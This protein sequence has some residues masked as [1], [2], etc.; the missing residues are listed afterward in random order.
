MVYGQNGKVS[1]YVHPLVDGWT[2]YQLP[3]GS[4]P[5]SHHTVVS[6]LIDPAAGPYAHHGPWRLLKD[7]RLITEI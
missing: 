4:I 7:L 6:L 5:P 2:G 1:P 3:H